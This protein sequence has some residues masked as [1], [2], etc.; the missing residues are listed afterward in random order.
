LLP[1]APFFAGRG[2]GRYYMDLTAVAEGPAAL[3]GGARCP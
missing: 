1:Q 2:V 3:L